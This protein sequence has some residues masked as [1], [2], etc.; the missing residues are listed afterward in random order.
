MLRM[1]R[2]S[3]RWLL[4]EEGL[5]SRRM[6]RIEEGRDVRGQ[7]HHLPRRKLEDNC[8]N[9]ISGRNQTKMRGS[10]VEGVRE[11]VLTALKASVEHR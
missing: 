2:G 9:K 1:R 6:R 4:L 3:C 5:W 7:Q 10:A 8:N 11:T